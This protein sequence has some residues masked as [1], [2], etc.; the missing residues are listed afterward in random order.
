[1]E[2]GRIGLIAEA[3][4]R[5][6]RE[7][8]E[9]VDQ[10]ARALLGALRHPLD[11]AQMSAQAL[12]MMIPKRNPLSP[13]MRERS[14]RYRY[15]ALRFQTEELRRAGKC[16]GCS[17]SAAFLTGLTGGLRIYHSRHGAPVAR[18]RATVPMS[19]R[20]HGGE[21]VSGNEL[22]L[23]RVELPVEEADPRKRMLE[24]LVLL[25]KQRRL[26]LRES[27]DLMARV[28]NR[29][30]TVLRQPLVGFLSKG[31]DLVASSIAGLPEPLY[32]AGA[33]VSRFSMFGPTAGTAV[34]ATLFSYGSISDVA[35][36]IDPAAIPDTGAFRECVAEGFDEMLK[37]G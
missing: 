19:L 18:L 17:V 3:L 12:G 16:L 22:A 29:V 4:G 14:S 21:A 25:R 5:R 1:V 37:L 26:P 7:T 35:L 33:R 2:P 36:N 24:I 32:M 13:I 23:A 28:G 20:E 6:L 10:S 9:R 31:Y 30:P 15:F 11:S 8:P 27:M 34:N